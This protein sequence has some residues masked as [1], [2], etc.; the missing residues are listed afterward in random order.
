MENEQIKQPNPAPGKEDGNND[1]TNNYIEQ[2]AKIK[3]THV[4]KEEYDKV[5]ADNKKM[6]ELL[7]TG[8][9]LDSSHEEPAKNRSSEELRKLLF[10]EDTSPSNLEYVKAVVELRENL[11]KEGCPDPFLPWG[12][13]I[14]PTPEDVEC[15]NRVATAFKECI[16]YANGDS[17]LFTNE[18][19]R[20]TKD[21]MPMAGKRNGK[22]GR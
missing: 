10:G 17:E 6:A 8:G 14:A 11:I 2:L 9:S 4:P 15:A 21:A 13:N 7:A 22:N 3:E 1:A 20:I 16:E 19:M 18:L 12:K 5:L